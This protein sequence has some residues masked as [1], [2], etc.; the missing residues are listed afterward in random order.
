MQARTVRRL[1]IAACVVGVAGMI[2]T[3]ILDA[4]GGAL[5]FGLFTAV[6]AFGMILV[7]AVTTGGAAREDDEL[8]EAIEDRVRRL[9]E[10]GSDE[11]DL[12]A[13]IRDAMRL[14]SRR[15]G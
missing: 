11:G 15:A 3:S 2:V 10:G 7:T 1:L 9:V 6:A 5:T 14:G 4:A 13:L 12:R 8:G